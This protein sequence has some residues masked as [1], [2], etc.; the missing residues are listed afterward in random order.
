MTAALSPPVAGNHPPMSSAT[1]R[2][3][4]WRRTFLDERRFCASWERYWF[5]AGEP[6]LE[7]LVWVSGRVD[8]AQTEAIDLEAAQS[9]GQDQGRAVIERGCGHGPCSG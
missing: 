7:R 4:S 3:S 9:G 5:A 1:R 2:L 6:E 8:N